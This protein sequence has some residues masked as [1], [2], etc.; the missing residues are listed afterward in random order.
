M[1]LSVIVPVY[2]EGAAVRDFL[3]RL[4]SYIPEH[5]EVLVVYDFPED[6]TAEPLAEYATRERRLRPTLNTY[7][8]GPAY[9]LRFGFDAA[10]HDVAVVTMADGSDDVTQIPTLAALIEDGAVVAAASRYMPGGEQVGGPWLKKSLSRLA[11]VS[12]FH[13][14]RVGTHDATNSFK[15]Y[16]TDFVRAAGVASTAGFEIGMELVAKA[17]RARLPVVEI[18]TV[19]HDREAGESRFRLLRW[20]PKYLRWYVHALGPRRPIEGLSP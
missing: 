6:T 13:L 1:T 3:D 11:G 20:I 19:W 15:A 2:N 18:P 16:S 12:L 4:F 5:G 8:R 7:G 14:G 10:R 17:R 9:A